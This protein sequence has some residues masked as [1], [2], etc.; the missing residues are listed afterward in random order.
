MKAQR[1]DGIT[2]GSGQEFGER[3]PPG[4]AAEVG[5]KPALGRGEAGGDLIEHIIGDIDLATWLLGSA[6]SEI[7]AIRRG[8]PPSSGTSIDM[9]D[10][11]QIHFRFPGGGMALL[12]FAV[13]LPAGRGSPSSGGPVASWAPGGACGS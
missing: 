10:Y 1:C 11:V 7:Y 5:L 9:P 13:N 12:D 2:A 8:K 3:L 6:P 4:L